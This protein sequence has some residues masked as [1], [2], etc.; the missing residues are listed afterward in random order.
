MSL[1]NLQ[2]TILAVFCLALSGCM[3]LGGLSY[4]QA[5]VVKQEGFTLTDEGWSLGLPERLLFGFNES[6]IKPENQTDI[7][8]LATQLN[9][10]SLDKLRIVG[11]TD[12]VGNPDYNLKLSEERAQ[13]VANVFITQKFDPQNL[14]VV[15]KGSTQPIHDNETEEHRAENRRV[16]VIIIP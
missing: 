3:N 1:R 2:L 12:N 10:Y 14:K 7:A 8:R 11:H 5:R 13:S 16:T 6:T 4:K 9:K 15:G